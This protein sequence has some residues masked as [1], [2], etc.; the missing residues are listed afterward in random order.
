MRNIS[1]VDSLHPKNSEGE[2]ILDKIIV[3]SKMLENNLSSEE[4]QV[5]FCK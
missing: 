1:F 5:I 3:I 2:L 4:T